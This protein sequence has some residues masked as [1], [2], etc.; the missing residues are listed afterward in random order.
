MAHGLVSL[1][2]K[3]PATT[4]FKYRAKVE[5]LWIGVEEIASKTYKSQLL[6]LETLI[7]SLSR[8]K[9]VQFYHSKDDPPF[10]SLDDSLRWHYPAAIFQALNG[11]QG[12]AERASGAQR[13]QPA[14]LAEW[15]WNRRLMGPDLNLESIKTLHQTPS[16]SALKKVSFLNYQTPSLHA[17][18]NADDA[19]LAARDETFIQSMADAITAL[20]VLDHLS[21]ESS[22]AVN[23][24]LLQLLPKSLKV[25]ELVNCWDVNGDDFARYLLSNGYKL[26]HL[27]LRHNQSLDLA[28]LTVLAAACPNLQTLRMDF[29]TFNHHEFYRDSDPNYENLLTADQIP[30]WPETL[31]TL[32]LKNMRKWT[33]EAAETLFQSLIDSA[34]KLL[35]LRRLDLKAMLDI[36]YRQRSQIRDKWEAKLK[37]VF[38]REKR[39][40][41]PFF[42]LRQQPSTGRQQTDNETVKT[43]SGKS[44]RSA[45][46][47]A[48]AMV[49]ESPSRWSSRIAMHHRSGPSS[50]ASSVGRGLRD[51]RG[52][53]SYAEP[54]TDT[55]E[56]DE[57][58]G[59]EEKEVEEE[60]GEESQSGSG[61]P[62]SQV[63]EA[64]TFRHGM[65]EKVEIQLD[66]QKPAEKTFGM[67]DFL[68]DEPDDLSDEEWNGDGEDLEVDYAW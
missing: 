39:D 56:D 13:L 34:P 23:G 25:L 33:A 16:F 51:G 27:I 45:A 5:E 31:K 28:F 37:Q 55:D 9:V 67:E 64:A 20:P 1:L 61:S 29:K 2:A 54:D 35:N 62:A 63:G 60:E 24:D 36:P 4:T 17:K 21:I 15:Q 32:E 47:A 30:T 48:R 7:G 18:E 41:L 42:S 59:E 50:R 46:A 8:L 26:E 22:T 68:D 6:D 40:P 11:M 58:D 57:E 44:R 53:P 49:A 3:D 14:N 38:L 12:S 10:R 19:E 52:R 43:A 66:N 65:C